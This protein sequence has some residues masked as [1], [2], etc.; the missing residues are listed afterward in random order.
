MVME[1]MNKNTGG[2]FKKG[3]AGL[4]AHIDLRIGLAAKS[5]NLAAAA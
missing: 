3:R 4:D 1:A 2:V 5:A